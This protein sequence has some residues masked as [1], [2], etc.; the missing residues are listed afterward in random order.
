[1]KVFGS[2][3]GIPDLITFRMLA[4]FVK[5]CQFCFESSQNT[6]VYEQ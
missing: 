1:M 4:V 6:E 2:E 3:Y 5:L